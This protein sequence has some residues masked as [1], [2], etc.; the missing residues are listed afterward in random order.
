MDG[1]LDRQL[2]NE[3]TLFTDTKVH[4]YFLENL[5][6]FRKYLIPWLSLTSTENALNIIPSV[7]HTSFIQCIIRE[8]N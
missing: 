7:V 2:F 4:L 8:I 5:S 6:T 3:C 1:L